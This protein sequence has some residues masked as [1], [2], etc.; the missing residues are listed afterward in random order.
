MEIQNLKNIKMAIFG[1]SEISKF[2]FTYL[3]SSYV[4]HFFYSDSKWV[5]VQY[6][7]NEGV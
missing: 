4:L 7:V 5:E 1:N 3:K 2:D 6:I